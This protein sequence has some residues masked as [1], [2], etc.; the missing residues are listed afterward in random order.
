[1]FIPFTAVT[2][3]FG[4]QF[5][6]YGEQH[7]TVNPDFWVLWIIAVPLTL[8][9]MTAWRASEGDTL[10][11][12]SQSA[13]LPLARWWKD[14]RWSGRGRGSGTTPGATELQNMGFQN[15]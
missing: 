2:S 11:W 5:F 14:R 9:I 1:M 6:D 7:M 8:V 13:R 12:S 15:V 3:I 4:T 10:D